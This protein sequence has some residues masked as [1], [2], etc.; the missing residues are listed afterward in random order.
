M[1]QSLHSGIL[2]N[3]I[4]RDGAYPLFLL[5]FLH[6]HRIKSL[7]AT[8]NICI[9]Y[10]SLSIDIFLS[11]LPCQQSL[12]DLALKL[13]R[14]A[15]PTPCNLADDYIPFSLM[16]I[17]LFFP[18]FLLVIILYSHYL[19]LRSR[20]RYTHGHTHTH[21]HT[22]TRA[23]TFSSSPSFSVLFSFHVCIYL[24]STS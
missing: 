13:R 18:L 17:S 6:F 21:T 23:R 1:Y 24:K 20:Y 22:H 4:D 10:L 9:M 8:T 12:F 7:R 16:L 3:I 19:F 2:D 5:F 11:F 15:T 14:Y